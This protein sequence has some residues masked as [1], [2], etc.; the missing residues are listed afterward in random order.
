[1]SAVTRPLPV[2]GV[3]ERNASTSDVKS[4]VARSGSADTD[5]G[6]RM[7]V[8]PASTRAGTTANEP[9]KSIDQFVALQRPHATLHLQVG[10]VTAKLEHLVFHRRNSAGDIDERRPQGIQPLP[11]R[12]IRRATALF[13]VPLIHTGTP[14]A[15]PAWAS[16]GY[17][18]ISAPPI[19][20][21]RAA[22]STTTGRHRACGRGVVHDP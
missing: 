7:S 3:T 17:R 5:S 20:R 16:G 12:A 15:V 21:T 11:K 22:G 6:N 4:L 18:R 2:Q 9:S 10:R 8:T 13:T 19:R 14:P 1:M